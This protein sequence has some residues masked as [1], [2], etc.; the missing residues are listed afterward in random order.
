MYMA[1]M[2]AS[3]SAQP[4][5]DLDRAFAW[6]ASVGV[7]IDPERLAA[8]RRIAQKWD[9]CLAGR[10]K[11]GARALQPIV[12]T[13]VD[14]AAAYATVHRAFGRWPTSQLGS[15]VER[16]SDAARGPIR[17]DDARNAGRH[18]ARDALFEAFTTAVLLEAEAGPGA[19]PGAPSRMA[20]THGRHRVHVECHRFGTGD[21]IGAG[22]SDACARLVQVFDAQPGA[23]KRGLV[24]M[25]ASRL[26][27]PPAPGQAEE[28]ACMDALLAAF[29]E[30]HVEPIQRSLMP[31][32][33]RIIGVM[34]Y[35]STLVPTRDERDFVHLAR[36]VVIPRHLVNIS[37]FDLL[38]RL[39]ELLDTDARSP[40]PA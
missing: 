3:P 34:A 30:R 31:V 18:P 40:V 2:Q 21:D 4:V 1:S 11:L 15:M 23:R 16:L 25:D 7:E 28:P 12:A 33:R 13:L 8:Y 10:G 37:E 38:D 22:I 26:I 9:E 20:I 19:A 5:G 17:I 6:M 36:W 14:D 29:I 24:A 35:A 32:D 27:A 39:S